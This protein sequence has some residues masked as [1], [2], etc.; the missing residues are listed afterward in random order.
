LPRAY[1]DGGASAASAPAPA[2][3]CDAIARPPAPSGLGIVWVADVNLTGAATR[4]TGS[5]GVVATGETVY[6]SASTLYVATTLTHD[7]APPA[8][9]GGSRPAQPPAPST[10]V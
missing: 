10:A 2:L 5:A 9:D 4:V 7:A 8:S 3:G 1:T 6:A